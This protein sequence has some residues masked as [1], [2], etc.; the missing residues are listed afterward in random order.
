MR[1]CQDGVLLRREAEGVPAHGVKDVETFHSP[2][3]GDRIQQ[4]GG[5]HETRMVASM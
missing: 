3:P 5:G 4:R 1:P 2:V